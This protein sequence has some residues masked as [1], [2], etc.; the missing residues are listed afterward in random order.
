VEPDPL[1]VTK[2]REGLEGIDRPE[3][4]LLDGTGGR[5]FGLSVT[6]R[7]TPLGG[8]LNGAGDTR[9]VMVIAAV[10]VWIF[11][12]P[13]SYLF[14]VLFGFGAVAVWWS[15]NISIVVHSALITKRYFAKRWIALAKES[16]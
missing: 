16:I 6:A 15:M 12:I 7:A 4:R 14:G 2:V 9:G 3:Q 13:L 11:R 8:A 10:S 5:K 1:L